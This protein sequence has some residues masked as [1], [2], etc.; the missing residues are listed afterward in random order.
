MFTPTKLF[1]FM[2]AAIGGAAAGG[3]VAW[4]IASR[5]ARIAELNDRTIVEPHVLVVLCVAGGFLAFPLGAAAG[6][7]VGWL[8]NRL[9]E[10]LRRS[11]GTGDE[12]DNTSWVTQRAATEERS[13]E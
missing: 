9:G 13:G 4:A 2:C 3:Y 12:A 6:L 7:I 5:F 1:Y 10:Y 11:T 8:G